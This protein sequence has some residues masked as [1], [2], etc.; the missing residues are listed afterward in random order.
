MEIRPY[1]ALNHLF[2]A[3]AGAPRPS[4]YEAPGHVEA[5]VV[6]DVAAFVGRL[7]V[8]DERRY[9]LSRKW[10]RSVRSSLVK[11]MSKRRS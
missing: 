1:P 9:R 3:G 11:P 7:P 6:D 8:P 2:I 10:T 4:E 5:A